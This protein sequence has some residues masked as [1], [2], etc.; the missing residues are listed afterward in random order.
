MH[1]RIRSVS[2]LRS[3]VRTGL[4]SG[5][6]KKI[7]NAFSLPQDEVAD[8]LGIPLR[9]ITRRITQTKL[10]PN[11][12]EKVVRLARL[13]AIAME[14]FAEKHLTVSKWFLRPNRSLGGEAPMKL[15]DSDMGARQVEDILGR[16]KEGVF[17]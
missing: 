8:A 11:E 17:S 14:V 1:R 16:I 3:L 6:F 5:S 7:V 15:L 4:P 13:F 2:D 12:S 9:T 10:S